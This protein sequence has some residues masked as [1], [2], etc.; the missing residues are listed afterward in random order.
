MV[1]AKAIRA[2]A[3]AIPILELPQQTHRIN[4]AQLA[5][6]IEQA[7]RTTG[8]FYLSQTSLS[9]ASIDQAFAQAKAFFALP[10]AVKLQVERSPQTNCGYVPLEAEA[11]DPARPD[12]KEAFNLGAA[13]LNGR[14]PWPEAPEPSRAEIFRSEIFRSTLAS[15]Y[16]SCIQ[17]IAHPLL[18]AVALALDLPER[19]LVE[20]HQQNFCLRLL[21]YPTLPP[22]AE[23]ADPLRAGAHTDYGSLT[24]LF[25]E[26]QQGGLEVLRPQTGRTPQT[27]W[28]PVPAL[29]GKLLVNIGDALQRWTNDHWRSTPHR[30]LLPSAHPPRYSMALFCDPDPDVEI[31]PLSSQPGTGYP[32]ILYRDYLQSRFSA[33]YGQQ[34]GQ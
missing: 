31:A 9:Q 13:T 24:L 5:Q 12:Y 18:Q 14:S 7:C 23:T 3:A 34:H 27:D 4:M 19:F 21:H 33:T 17:Q 30:V 15:F 32:P 20:R 2:G 1:E 8:F 29:P 11:L 6:G 25:Q 28:M 22:S 10:A 16:Q 26:P